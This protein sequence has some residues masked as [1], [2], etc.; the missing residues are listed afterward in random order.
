L[1]NKLFIDRLNR[2]DISGVLPYYT[3]LEICGV[4]SFNLSA[5]EQQRWLYTFSEVYDV[6]VLDPYDALEKS[7]PI[8]DCLLE[9]TDY[10]L[11]KM[12][13]GDALFLREAE[14]YRTDAI[15][16]WNIKHFKDR[17]NIPLATPANWNQAV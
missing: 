4:T 9:L 6:K 3:L 1:P 12:T 5:K 14:L 17:T 11:K 13:L 7:R 16:T 2:Q 10:I 15:V 8:G